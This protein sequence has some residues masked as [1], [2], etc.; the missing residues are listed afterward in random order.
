M[1][2]IEKLYY[3]MDK[4]NENWTDTPEVKAASDRLEEALGD[5]LYAKYEDEICNCTAA[6]HKEGFVKGFQYAISLLTGGKEAAV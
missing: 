4:L 1:N 2:S 3:N 5:E 6:N